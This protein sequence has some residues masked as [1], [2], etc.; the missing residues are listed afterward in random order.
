MGNN[1]MKKEALSPKEKDY[2]FVVQSALKS[3]QPIWQKFRRIWHIQAIDFKSTRLWKSQQE[4][5][6]QKERGAS[7]KGEPLDLFIRMIETAIPQKDLQSI[8]SDVL[9]Q[10]NSSRQIK[11]IGMNENKTEVKS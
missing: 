7:I 2:Q 4:M 8:K 5:N 10:L 11:W 3:Y 6:L 9:A 1:P